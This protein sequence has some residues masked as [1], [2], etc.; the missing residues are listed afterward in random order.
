MKNQKEFCIKNSMKLLLI[1]FL[2]NA[3][4]PGLK[5]SN[6]STASERV[7][8]CTDCKIFSSATTS[9][10]L[11][12]ATAAAAITA[13][14]AI[15][16][17]DANKPA[18]GATY[19]ALLVN[20]ARVGCTSAFCATDGELEHVDWVLFPNVTY[21]RSDGTTVIGTT[22]SASIFTSD[23]INSVEAG[24]NTVWTG[25]VDLGFPTLSN[26][27]TSSNCLNWT[28]SNGAELGVR[29]LSNDTTANALTSGSSFCSNAYSI[30]CVEQ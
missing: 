27:L 13:A 9:N 21:Y 2:A 29:G 10:G 19:K 25:L 4:G 8:V 1:L 26:F 16:M 18:D 22:N 23:F 15:C 30:Y 3:C 14:D 6:T 20:S 5:S 17:A 12:G 7:P 24:A 11:F 28:S